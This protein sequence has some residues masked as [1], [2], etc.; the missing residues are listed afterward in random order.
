A[1]SYRDRHRFQ[2]DVDA[3][4]GADLIAEHA[5]DAVLLVR[6]VH[7]KPADLVR[8]RAIREDVDRADVE[9]EA[10]RLAHVLADDDVPAA[11]W[12]LRRLLVSLEQRHR[13]PRSGGSWWFNT[14][15][16]G[17]LRQGTR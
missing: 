1:C 8:R 12:A 2:R 11:S 15:P 16:G 9:A 13:A 14:P 4:V 7:R 10:A 3:E 17:P 6:C 5:A